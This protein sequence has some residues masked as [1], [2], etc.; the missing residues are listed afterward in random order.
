MLYCQNIGNVFNLIKTNLPHGDVLSKYR[1]YSQSHSHPKL[2]ITALRD[3]IVPFGGELAEYDGNS[4][5]SLEFVFQEL[6]EGRKTATFV[7]FI[8]DNSGETGFICMGDVKEG[9][10][11]FYPKTLVNAWDEAYDID[12]K[13]LG[14]NESGILLDTETANW[15]HPEHPFNTGKWQEALDEDRFGPIFGEPSKLSFLPTDFNED[16]S[17]LWICPPDVMNKIGLFNWWW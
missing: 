4:G 12:T 14:V 5:P 9:K 10:I 16:I 13:S 2:V 6:V 11:T 17:Y 8:Y 7:L 15:W 3:I 1:R